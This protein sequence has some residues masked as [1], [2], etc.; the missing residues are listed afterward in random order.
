MGYTKNILLFPVLRVVLV[1]LRLSFSLSLFLKSR[2]SDGYLQPAIAASRSFHYV[3]DR[4][5]SCQ[6]PFYSNFF[7]NTH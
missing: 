5:R 6:R 2:L 7:H 4:S 1:A 3:V